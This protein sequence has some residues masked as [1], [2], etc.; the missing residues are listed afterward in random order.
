VTANRAHPAVGAA[1][2]V[3]LVLCAR[4]TWSQ[5]PPPEDAG[6]AP[7]EGGSATTEPADAET[8]LEVTVQGERGA[9]ASSTLTRGEARLLPGAFGDPF[10]A[11]EALPG[12]TPLASGVPYFYVRGAPPGN[13]GYFLDGIRIPLLYHLALGPS[14]IHPALIERVELHPGGYPARYGRAAGGIVAGETRPPLPEAHGEAGIRLVDAGGLIEAPLADGRGSALVGGRYSY[15]GAALSLFAPEIELDYWDYQG[16]LGWDFGPRDRVTLLVFGAHDFLSSSDDEG[17][18]RVHF[19]ATFHRADVRWDHQVDPQ[20]TIRHA[21]TVGYDVTRSFGALENEDRLLGARVELTHRLGPDAVVRGGTDALL[22]VTTSRLGD[23]L[24]PR[25]RAATTVAGGAHLDVTFRPVPEVELTPG[26]RVDLFASSG[27]AAVAA[28]PRAAA[29]FSV[30]DRVRIVHALGLAHQ[31]RDPNPL[32]LPGVARGGVRGG[33]QTA[34]QTSAG[35]EADLPLEIDGSVTFFQNAFLN[36]SDPLG[37]GGGDAFDVVHGTTDGK[38]SGVEVYVRRRLTRRLGGFVAYT[39]SRSVRYLPRRTTESGF[40]RAH[41]LNVALGY[42]FGRGW[43]A[44]TRAVFYTGTPGTPAHPEPGVRYPDRLPPFFRLDLRFEKRW[45]I[46]ATG[47][48]ALVLEG[49]NVTLSK[50]TLIVECDPSGCKYESLGPITIPSLGV[51]A[52]F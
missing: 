51:E 21:V 15:T 41:V 6:A 16:R 8:P 30:T 42:D 46:G 29:R 38:S 40:D 45:R 25:E 22:D 5:Q 1:W 4:P 14:V 19:D 44:G 32:P 10:R 39:L 48:I 49:Q 35:V 43:R 28:D 12:V 18:E 26:M 13:V 27:A 36:M 37:L 2:F 50:E 20:T 24:I 47:W 11:V 31:P 23:F 9:P 34:V 33:L 3:A 7:I 17:D 52:G